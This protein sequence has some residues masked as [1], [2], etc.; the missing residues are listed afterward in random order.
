MVSA[1]KSGLKSSRNVLGVPDWRDEN[2][3]PGRN[4]L[5]NEEWRWEFLRRRNDYRKDFA[6]RDE[7]YIEES[8][9]RYFERLYFVDRPVDPTR[10]VNAMKTKKPDTS[11]TFSNLFPPAFD[12]TFLDTDLQALYGDPFT[13]EPPRG[14]AQPYHLDLRVDLRHPL[15]PQFRQLRPLAEDAQAGWKRSLRLPRR[16]KWPLRRPHRDKWPLYLRV[17]DA[18]DAGAKLREIGEVVLGLDDYDAAAKR[19][20]ETLKAARR[21]QE[22]FPK[23]GDK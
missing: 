14:K 23:F 16:S 10:S 4:E 12:I 5:T 9:G 11:D 13:G 15:P 20:D 6:R 17:L 19:A 21:L 3:Y 1:N 22:D 18:R 7:S 2:S 8:K